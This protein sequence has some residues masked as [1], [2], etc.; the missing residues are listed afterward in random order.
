MRSQNRRLK[1]SQFLSI[2]VIVTLFLTNGG[3]IQAQQG[4][5]N[6]AE[7]MF[8][9]LKVDFGTV[10]RGA[11]TKHEIVLENLYEEDVH[12]V[13]VGTTCGC[14]AAKPDKKILKT[15]EKARIEVVMDTRKFMHRKDSNVDVTLEF[16]GAKGTASKT[17]RVPIT[18][19]IRSDVVLTPGNVDFG[20]VDFGQAVDKTIKVAYAGRQDWKIRGIKNENE[21]LKAQ[22]KEVERA[23]GRVTYH[24][25][26]QLDASTGLGAFQKKMYLLTD[27]QNSPEVP[28]LING[29]VA[30]DIEVV[31]G[32]LA[33]G[34]VTPGEVKQ[35]N[36]I[37]KGRKPFVI[38]TI[39]CENHP[40]CFE[41]RPLTADSKTVHVIPF[42]FTAPTKDGQ[43][44]ESFTIS[45]AGRSQPL[46]FE[47]NGVVSGS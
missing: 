28:V 32:Q 12:V 46:S 41:I 42:R 14:T 15:G 34:N 8:S 40:D 25:T 6:W 20:T 26:V 9:D 29:R 11:D 38:E 23:N 43:F 37:V 45:V 47:A 22:V 30:T 39:E 7:K 17:V 18:A 35:F 16:H 2:A 31:P 36:V 21:F 1:V 24:L 4:Q 10:A 27:D 13:N 33:L 3:T 5:L 44:T 19:Y